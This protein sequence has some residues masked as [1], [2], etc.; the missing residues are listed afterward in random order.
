MFSCNDGITPGQRKVKF[1]IPSQYISDG[2]LA[3]K[4]FDIGKLNLETVFP[5]E[6]RDLI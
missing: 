2:G 5:G 4:V 1:T 6:E 3:T